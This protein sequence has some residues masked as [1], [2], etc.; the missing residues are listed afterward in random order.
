MPVALQPYYTFMRVYSVDGEAARNEI[1][2]YYRHSYAAEPL[3]VQAIR[4]GRLP[5]VPV[6]EM[7]ILIRCHDAEYG[8]PTIALCRNHRHITSVL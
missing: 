1:N 3:A 8:Q 2:T 4:L 7:P 5:I 6:F